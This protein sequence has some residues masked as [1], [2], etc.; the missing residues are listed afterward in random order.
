[1]NAPFR[2]TLWFKRGEFAESGEDAP[3]PLPI[4][5]RYLDDGSTA[6]TDSLRFGLHSG[7]TLQI[8]VDDHASV[9]VV[10]LANTDLRTL[11]RELERRRV[12]MFAA[13]CASI[14][15]VIAVLGIGVL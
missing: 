11:A 10:S 3:V 2:E 7:H 9:E 13:V 6:P 8:P 4:E 12:R 14:C 5:D 1:M 15:A